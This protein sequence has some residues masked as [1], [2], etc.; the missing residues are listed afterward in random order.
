MS[1]AMH[2]SKKGPT[3]VALAKLSSASVLSRR[4]HS[5]CTVSPG[6][7]SLVAAYAT[8]RWD[9]CN[10]MLEIEHGTFMGSLGLF[11][12]RTELSL[13]FSNRCILMIIACSNVEAVVC[14]HYEH[15]KYSKSCELTK[16][17]TF[18]FVIPTAMILPS[19]DCISV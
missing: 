14:M 15:A 7:A 13:F 6:L 19:V 9:A 17:L 1:E 10:R 2:G 5:R 4:T 3:Y 8:A 12:A 18:E 16:H 11:A